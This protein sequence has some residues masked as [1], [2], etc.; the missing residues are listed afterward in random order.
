MSIPPELSEYIQSFI[1][2]LWTAVQS[3]FMRECVPEGLAWSIQV[4]T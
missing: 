4:F 2:G 3:H 1:L